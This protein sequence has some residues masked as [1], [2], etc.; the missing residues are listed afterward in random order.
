MSLE[1]KEAMC[2][3]IFSLFMDCVEERIYS[4]Y[5]VEDNDS[6]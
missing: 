4:L 6:V 5:A 3:L 2:D 1:L